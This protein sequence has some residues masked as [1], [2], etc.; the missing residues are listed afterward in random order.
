MPHTDV[1]P[2]LQMGRPHWGS[3]LLVPRSTQ[4]PQVRSYTTNRGREPGWSLLDAC[5][6]TEDPYPCNATRIRE[7]R[8][9]HI[10]PFHLAGTRRVGAGLPAGRTEIPGT[11]QASKSKPLGQDTQHKGSPCVYFGG[12]IGGRGVTLAFH[13]AVWKRTGPG[14]VSDLIPQAWRGPPSSEMSP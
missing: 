9:G 12:F 11:S 14:A 7:I 8:T 13:P 5:W 1:C 3:T 10:L 6:E 2:T 4:C